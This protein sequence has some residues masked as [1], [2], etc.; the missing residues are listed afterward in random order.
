MNKIRPGAYINVLTV[1]RAEGMEESPGA[2]AVGA[3]FSWGPED[4]LIF[5]DQEIFNSYDNLLA[6]TGF[7][8]TDDEL[9]PVALTLANVTEAYFF[10]TNTGGVKA[11]AQNTD[12]EVD[13]MYTGIVGNDIIVKY[14]A[15]DQHLSVLYKN[16]EVE[17]FDFVSDATVEEL[18]TLDSSWIKFT[19]A[20]VAL[21]TDTTLALAGG[22]NGS[23]TSNF[24]AVFAELL[25][26]NWDT[27][28]IVEGT[29][30]TN[31]A[32]TNFVDLARG[33]GK[34]VRG[35]V[36]QPSTP[37]DNEAIIRV[38]QGFITESYEVTPALFSAFVAGLESGGGVATSFTGKVIPGA[39]EIT[40]LVPTANK[41]IEDYLKKGY[42]LLTYRSDGAVVIEQDIN[43]FTSFLPTKSKV[44]RKNRV[45]RAL[46]AI[47]NNAK[48]TFEM[49]YIGK[50][51]NTE[52]GRESFRVDMI[53]YLNDL[54]NRQAIQNFVYE[55]DIVVRQGNDLE[56]VIVELSIQPV[57]SMEKL[58]MT[59]YVRY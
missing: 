6:L 19:S 28:A 36:V 48:L 40:T 25:R 5:I 33:Q 46:D 21:D 51:S 15:A 39:N 59:V 8:Q 14:V 27:L 23:T 18:L 45:L 57:D 32:I 34:K 50:V 4:K 10:R 43:T 16:N 55:T 42:F 38:D 41:D 52:N 22:T 12:Y 17:G 24:T 30:A 54:Q 7:T 20:D 31:T 53:L 9:R 44:F 3:T 26:K 13:A 11:S 29:A 58:Y 56:D 35:V 1:P 2:A 47:C 37:P 49:R